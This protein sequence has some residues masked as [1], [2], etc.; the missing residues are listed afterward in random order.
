MKA[1]SLT[2]VLLLLGLSACGGATGPPCDDGLALVGVTVEERR[3]SFC[4]VVTVLLS[5][6][7]IVSR[8]PS[9]RL[10]FVSLCEE[11]RAVSV[12]AG[13]LRLSLNSIVFR[14]RLADVLFRSE[15]ELRDELIAARD[16][17]RRLSLRLRSSTR[18]RSRRLTV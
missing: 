9:R 12:A 10:R 4:R 13:L 17:S 7:R 11:R 1:H 16:G 14:S 15:P 3:V 5:R 2:V 8:E 18:N 6:N